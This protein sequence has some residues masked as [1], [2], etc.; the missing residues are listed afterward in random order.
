MKNPGILKMVGLA[1]LV[2]ALPVILVSREIPDK[3]HD[4][5]HSG[6]K[7]NRPHPVVSADEK[8]GRIRNVFRIRRSQTENALME[9]LQ[10]NGNTDGHLSMG[11]RQ[12]IYEMPPA[13]IC[14]LLSSPSGFSGKTVELR[15]ALLQRLAE[16]DKR[17]AL[18]YAICKEH[19]DI[20]PRALTAI[21]G[22]WAGEDAGAAIAWARK[23]DPATRDTSFAMISNRLAKVDAIQAIDLAMQIGDDELG[24]QTAIAAASHWV[25]REPEEALKWLASVE[26]ESFRYAIEKRSILELANREGE[27]AA[28]YV[29]EAMSGHPEREALAVGVAQRWGRKNPVDAVRWLERNCSSVSGQS[30]ALEEIVRLWYGRDEVAVNNWLAGHERNAFRDIAIITYV[31]ILRSGDLVA[32][33]QWVRSISDR[34]LRQKARESLMQK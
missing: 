26:D 11:I 14:R 18:E 1:A 10:S 19:G 5:A 3:R 15:I 34:Q 22:V 13:D 6:E 12:K 2:V 8:G 20:K 25:A 29:R 7:T 21:L 17:Q 24:R 32:A 9:L 31:K 4:S 16:F 30:Q 28:S 27:V 33:R 23:L